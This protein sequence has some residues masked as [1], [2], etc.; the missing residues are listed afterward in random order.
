MLLIKI[1]GYTRLRTCCYFFSTPKASGAYPGRALEALGALVPRVV[2]G[3]LRKRRERKRK[4]K[5]D[6]KKEGKKGKKKEKDKST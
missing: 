5:K 3:V 4:G 1:L 2:K 6:R